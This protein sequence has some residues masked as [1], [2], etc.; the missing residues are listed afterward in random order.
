[1]TSVGSAARSTVSLVIGASTSI[2][3]LPSTQAEAPTITTR[4]TSA[5]E[6]SLFDSARD[7]WSTNPSQAQCGN[8]TGLARTSGLYLDIHEEVA[9]RLGVCKS[10]VAAGQGSGGRRVSILPGEPDGSIL[11]FRMES[12]APGIAMPELGRQTVHGEAVEVIREWI[13]QMDGSCP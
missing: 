13:E 5:A 10:P 7:A 12:I 1:M 2:S 6:P 3:L 9:A 11:V 8:P 4:S